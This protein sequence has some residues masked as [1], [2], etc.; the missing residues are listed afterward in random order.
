M[1]DDMKCNR[2]PRVVLAFIWVSVLFAVTQAHDTHRENDYSAFHEHHH[3][4]DGTVKCGAH[5]QRH[6]YQKYVEQ[7]KSWHEQLLLHEGKATGQQETGA[8]RKLTAST[9][10]PIRIHAEFQIANLNADQA[11]LIKSLVNSAIRSLQ[12]FV[13]IRRP[14]NG[15]LLVP[16]WCIGQFNPPDK[17]LQQLVPDFTQSN[18]GFTCGQATPN[19]SHFDVGYKCS[20]QWNCN[21]QPAGSGEATDMYLYV[22]AV[23]DNGCDDQ[24]L[25]Y[26]VPCAFDRKYG[27]AG[28][29][30][31]LI[32]NANICPG[33]LSNKTIS[34]DRQV[35]VIAHEIL[36]AMGFQEDMFEQYIDSSGNPLGRDNVV[37]SV[38]NNGK[39]QSAIITPT[40]VKV[41]RQYYG[42]SSLGGVPLEDEGGDGTAGSHWEWRVLQGDVMASVLPQDGSSPQMTDFTLALLN[43][44]GWY[45]PIWEDAGW[46]E[47]GRGWGCDFV[48]LSCYDF[49]T[50]YPEQKFFCDSRPNEYNL[51]SHLGN[52]PGTCAPSSVANG[53]STIVAFSSIAGCIIEGAVDSNNLPFWKYGLDSRCYAS[54]NPIAK[55]NTGYITTWGRDSAS[56]AYC[57][58]SQCQGSKLQVS[59]EGKW[60]DCPTGSTVDLASNTVNYKKGGF[61]PC[62]NNAEYCSTLSCDG[63]CS[64]NGQ[65]RNG[66]CYCNIA[67]IGA[68]CSERADGLPPFPPPPP[69]EQDPLPGQNIIRA[70]NNYAQS[71]AAKVV[72]QAKN[73]IVRN[74]SLVII[75]AASVGAFLAILIAIC[76]IRRLCCS[77]KL[78][79][80]Q[81][82]PSQPPQSNPFA[83]QQQQQQFQMSSANGYSAANG[84]HAANGRMPSHPAYG[85]QNGYPARGPANPGVDYG[86]MGNNS[87]YNRNVR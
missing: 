59:L 83:G 30:R 25:A 80:A 14:V 54:K 57:L 26:A 35:G 78:R 4:H 81:Y 37:G 52:A 29:N 74:K 24:Y 48:Q 62:P 33:T 1:F 16:R 22:T 17:C 58:L 34:F 40:V 56:D 42:C 19:A 44:T 5:A 21:T 20:N 73:W 60:V 23:N 15:K 46:I 76:C 84:Y 36:H 50:K 68:N 72:D 11:S 47:W 51:C 39:S 65:C 69:G 49:M 32:G 6:H 75:I 87:R 13:K 85:Y 31:P 67:F 38:L 71:Q 12:K 82:R 18:S 66:T 43:D 61:G 9:S 63:G 53:C 27:Q 2:I 41:A 77:P 8:S 3:G 79:G 64:G 55:Q 28:T 45:E 86:N 7:H 70:P 10:W